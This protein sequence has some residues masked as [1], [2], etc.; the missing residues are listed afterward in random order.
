MPGEPYLQED[1]T[2][3][4][5]FSP[6]AAVALENARLYKESLE[7]GRKLELEVERATH[8]LALANDQLRDLDKAKSEFLSIASHQLYTPLTALRGYLSMI[9][10]GDFGR[11]PPKQRP[12]YDILEK[13]AARLI[14]LIRELLDISRIESG[15]L[16]LNLESIDLAE[17]T[18]T[19]IRDIMPN[20]INK[21]LDLIFDRPT[22]KLP[23]IGGDRQRLRQVVLTGSVGF[24]YWHFGC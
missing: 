16:E 18:A 5:S 12:V 23:R 11:V 15:R 17:M 9:K 24:S 1:I 3:L 19:L 14:T 2:F 8:E 20:A 6:Q 21:D 10:E 22:E 13:S 7:F 4:S